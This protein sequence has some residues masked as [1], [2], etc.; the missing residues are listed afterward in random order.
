M[1]GSEAIVLLLNQ[2]YFINWKV[3]LDSLIA[4]AYF[5]SSLPQKFKQK[6]FRKNLTQKSDKTAK[7]K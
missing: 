7:T 6:S 1:E 4:P 2:F 5:P 3:N